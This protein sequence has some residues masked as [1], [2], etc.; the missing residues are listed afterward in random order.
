MKKI[1][2]AAERERATTYNKRHYF[3]SLFYMDDII[4]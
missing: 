1:Q 4:V 3:V 2:S